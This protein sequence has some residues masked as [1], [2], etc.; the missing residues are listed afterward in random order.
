[1]LLYTGVFA[2][3]HGQLTSYCPLLAQAYPS[4][5]E[6][7]AQASACARIKNKFASN[8]IRYVEPK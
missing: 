2:K 6:G 1:M 7:L 3:L 4:T 8:C 5:S